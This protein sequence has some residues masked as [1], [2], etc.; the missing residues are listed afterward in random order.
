MY[1]I[2]VTIGIE[3]ELYICGKNRVVRKYVVFVLKIIQI[4][5]LSRCRQRL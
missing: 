5:K 2:E 1:I 3:I 4:Y